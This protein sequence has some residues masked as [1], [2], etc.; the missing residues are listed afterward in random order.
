MDAPGFRAQFPVLE[1]VAYLN[2]GT[3]GPLPAGAAAA[4]KQELERELADGRSVAHFD[5]RR[6]LVSELRAAY[7]GAL[8]C[9]TAD[10]ALT[11][12][13]TEGMAQVIFGLEL[14]RGD[15]VIT[16]DEEHPGLLGA[17]GAAQEILG[18]EVR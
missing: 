10:V 1:R 4:G 17:L 7:A 3:D 2:A 13:T 12:C 11:S 6:T 15:E 14:A 5:R 9:Q 18:V 8:G 16:S